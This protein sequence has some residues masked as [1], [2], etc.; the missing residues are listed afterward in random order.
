MNFQYY[1]ILSSSNWFAVKIY[2]SSLWDWPQRSPQRH[3]VWLIFPPR[4]PC[5]RF[6]PF[7]GSFTEAVDWLM[8]K[9]FYACLRSPRV[10]LQTFCQNISLIFFIQCKKLLSFSTKLARRN[11]WYCNQALEIHLPISS[12]IVCKFWFDLTFTGHWQPF[13][14]RVFGESIII[15]PLSWQNWEKTNKSIVL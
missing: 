7:L 14:K 6:D 13:T 5:P 2:L 15:H 3:F 10:L 1:D 4:S 9:T 12:L 8:H 11:Q